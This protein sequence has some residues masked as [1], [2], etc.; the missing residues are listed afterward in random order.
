MTGSGSTGYRHEDGMT[1]WI[2]S[3]RLFPPAPADADR[4]CKT[5]PRNDKTRK[6]EW[7]KKRGKEAVPFS[8]AKRVRLICRAG[9]E[10]GSDLNK[11]RGELFA[12]LPRV[13]V[14]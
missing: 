12:K 13:G 2:A 8:R 5:A 7:D 6:Y 14:V 9:G 10:A 4:V 3:S 11:K 1:N